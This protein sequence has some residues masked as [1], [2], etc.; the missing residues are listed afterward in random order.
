MAKR[1]TQT[2]RIQ[3]IEDLS[4]RNVASF[5]S[6]W[7]YVIDPKTMKAMMRRGQVTRMNL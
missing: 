6:L 5:I 3:V 4:R 7:Y 1:S 2:S